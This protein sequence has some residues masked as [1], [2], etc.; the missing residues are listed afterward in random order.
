MTTL[1][2]GSPCPADFPV[3]IEG[4]VEPAGKPAGKWSRLESR[5]WRL[6]ISPEPTDRVRPRS[7]REPICCQ[8]RMK[9]GQSSKAALLI[10]TREIP[11]QPR[12]GWPVHSHDRSQ[13]SSSS[14]GAALG[15]AVTEGDRWAWSEIGRPE[16]PPLT[17]LRN[18][19]GPL[20]IDR[21]VLR[22][23]IR[24][25]SSGNGRGASSPLRCNTLRHQ[26][27]SLPNKWPISRPAESLR[28]MG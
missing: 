24:R 12:Q 10:R 23:L 4:K 16:G 18:H 27:P 25:D 13:M 7:R 11:A 26:P 19:F 15:A 14:I 5:R 20:A 8:T 22:T 17:G 6:A 21:P 2:F 3:G 9:K 28:Y 1:S